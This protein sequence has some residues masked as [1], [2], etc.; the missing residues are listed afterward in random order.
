MKQVHVSH[1]QIISQYDDLMPYYIPRNRYTIE[2]Y[3]LK[4]RS[5]QKTSRLLMENQLW[6][7]DSGPTQNMLT[8]IMKGNTYP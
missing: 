6:K 5:G 1:P 7:K 8:P 3:N 4:F 2:I